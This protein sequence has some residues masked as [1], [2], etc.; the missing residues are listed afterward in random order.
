MHHMYD[1]SV[2][3]YRLF[4][5]FLENLNTNWETFNS[6]I[7]RKLNNSRI[8]SELFRIQISTFIKITLNFLSRLSNV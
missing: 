3:Y 4:H 2:S 8:L 5:S 6:E 7:H 1:D